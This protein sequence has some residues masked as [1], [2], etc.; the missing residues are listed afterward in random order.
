MLRLENVSKYY[1]TQKQ[2]YRGVEKINL[3]IKEGE[4]VAIVGTSGTG[5]STLLNPIA[6][7]WRNLNPLLTDQHP[8]R[9]GLTI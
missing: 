5:K 1:G 4:A 3:T 2:S 8:D 6:P 9:C 7:S